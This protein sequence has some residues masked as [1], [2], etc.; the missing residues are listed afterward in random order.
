MKAVVY[1]S[2]GGREVLALEDIADPGAPGAEELR[3]R[4]LA[5]S[6][7]PVDRKVREGQLKLIAG[8]HFPKRP[9]LDFC[10]IVEAIGGSVSGF[11]VGDVAYGSTGSMSDGAFAEF[12]IVKSSN[13]AKKPASLE[14]TT[15]AGVPVVAI[16]ALQTVR[17]MVKAKAGDEI[18]VNGCTGGVGLFALQ[19]APLFGAKATGS[20]GTDSVSIAL[21][22]G[23]SEVIDYRKKPVLSHPSKFRAILEL[24]GKLAFDDARTLLDEDGVYIDFSPSPLSL[25]GNTLANPFRDQKHLFAM[26]GAN[27]A[28][29]NWL[30]HEMDKGTLRPAPTSVYPLERFREA[31]EHAEGGG[32]IGKT[33]VAI[34][35]GY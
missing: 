16:A 30:A 15:A 21:Q 7:N 20:C 10:G 32:V 11:T 18:L 5:A 25:I 13:V 19:L 8:G 6:V 35:S 4:V 33:V 26:T 14:A 3:I 28:D 31:F 12:I 9:G 1:H 24:S 2:N 23:A 29:L 22:F 27:T 34:G 17:D